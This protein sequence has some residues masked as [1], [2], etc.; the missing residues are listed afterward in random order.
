M[1]ELYK[2]V[3]EG[4]LRLTNLKCFNNALKLSWIKWLLIKDQ[5]WQSL[6]E[7]NCGFKQA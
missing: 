1:T 2:K 7:K 4:G 3:S 5:Q 6:F